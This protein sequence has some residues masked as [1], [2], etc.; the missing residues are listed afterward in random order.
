[1]V[2]EQ[3]KENNPYFSNNTFLYSLKTSQNIPVFWYFQVGVEM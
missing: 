2:F 1:M 3:K